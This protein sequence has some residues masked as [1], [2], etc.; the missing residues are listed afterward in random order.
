V[1]LYADLVKMARA[2]LPFYAREWLKTEETGELLQKSLGRWKGRLEGSTFTV[3]YTWLHR[4]LHSLGKSPDETIEWAR[5]AKDKYEVLD[6][7]QAFVNSLTARYNTKRIAYATIR[8]FFMH[9]RVDLPPDKHFTIRG[10]KK[11]AERNLRPEH[12]RRILGLAVEP[13]RSAILVKW[14]ALTDNQGLVQI[15][16]NCAGDV[17]KALKENQDVCRLNISGRKKMKN[18]RTFET[19]IGPEPLQALREYFDQVRGWPGP[20]EPIWIYDTPGHKGQGI[21]VRAFQE[22]WMRLL[23]RAKYVH[24]QKSSSSGVRYGYNMHN[25]RDLVISLLVEVPNLKDLCVEYWAGHEIDPLAYRDLSLRPQ[26]VEEQYRLAV[27]YLSLLTDAA[28]SQETKD[29][30]AEVE[31]LKLAVRMLQDASRLTVTIPAGGENR[32]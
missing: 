19:F 7:I 23:R 30:R 15:S 14:H 31:Q 5:Q 25:T 18:V 28:A 29:L 32:K 13:W 10:D 22:A 3:Y 20:G 11:P 4:F 12:V 8:S 21:K 1:Y 16:N 26:F 24:E 2:E 27:P 6:A 17:V 9:N